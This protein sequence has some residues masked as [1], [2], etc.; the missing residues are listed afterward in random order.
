MNLNRFRALGMEWNGVEY[1][2]AG[3]DMDQLWSLAGMFTF[4]RWAAAVFKG[5]SLNSVFELCSG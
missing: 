2:S 3:V 5:V 4:T 1:S